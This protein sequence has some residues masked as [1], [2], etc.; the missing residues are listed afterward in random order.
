MTDPLVS[1]L[2]ERGYRVF[3]DKESIPIGELWKRRLG[4]AVWQSRVC[5]MCWSQNARNSEYVLFEYS[6]A[7]A[8]GKCVLRWLLD[9]TALPTM[10]ELQGVTER[11]PAR[12]SQEF[13]TRL[14]P[15]LSRVRTIQAACAALLLAA[16]FIAFWWAQRPAPPFQFGGRVIESETRLPI[17]G[18]RVEAQYDRY[19]AYTDADGRYALRLP[20]PKPRYLHL[21]FVKAGYKAEEAVNIPTDGLEGRG[22][23]D[24][25]RLR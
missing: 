20:Q 15:P 8:L 18:V 11:D 23:T 14:G 24:M 3:Y 6:R 10:I 22:D 9:S 2:R 1:A 25:V 5:V 13:V 21:V 16:L 19:V 17:R 7:E 4:K 12:A